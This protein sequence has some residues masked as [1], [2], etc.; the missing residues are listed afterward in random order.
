MKKNRKNRW[1]SQAAFFVLLLTVFLCGC[2][3]K[4]EKISE[5]E[6]EGTFELEEVFWEGS[7]SFSETERKAE[8]EE[9]PEPKTAEASEKTEK[10]QTYYVHV[11]GAVKTPGV[12]EMTAGK[13][14]FEALEAAGGFA[15]DACIDYVNQAAAV[16]DGMKL[17]IP[18]LKETEEMGWKHPDGKEMAGMGSS[19]AENGKDG[20]A[21]SC[22]EGKSVGGLVDINAASA[23]LLCTLNGIG[24]A[25]AQAIIAYREA[26][27]DFAK[28][29]DIMKVAGIKQNGYEKIKDQICVGWE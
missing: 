16:Y 24:E 17:W 1:C 23:E 19:S 8:A 11:C 5:S 12:Y 25:K 6:L 7:E 10:L 14:I 20:Y 3:R 21:I 29:E 22:S 9:E 15:E 26:H 27:G 28:K 13:R 2:T 4:P 18:T